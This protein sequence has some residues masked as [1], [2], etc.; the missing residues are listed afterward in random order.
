[1]KKY[2]TKSYSKKKIKI[3]TISECYVNEAKADMHQFI[4]NYSSLDIEG[5]KN[6]LIQIK[7]IIC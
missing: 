1:M 2:W 6:A 5:L 4:L 3:G 7:K